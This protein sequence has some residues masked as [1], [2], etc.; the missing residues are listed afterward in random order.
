[1]DA[2][3]ADLRDSLRL[4]RKAPGFTAT[5]SATLALGIGTNTAI[6]SAVNAI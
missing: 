1:M 5:A 6:F 2:L 3:L 4:L